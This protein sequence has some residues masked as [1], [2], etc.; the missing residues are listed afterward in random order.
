MSFISAP[1]DKCDTKTINVYFV[2]HGLSCANMEK[3]AGGIGSVLRLTQLDPALS[4]VGV[5]KS[6]EQGEIV[7]RELEKRGVVLDV[8]FTSVMLRA[9]E[10]AAFMFPSS[11]AIYPIPNVIEEGGSVANFAGSIKEQ[12]TYMRKNNPRLLARVNFGLARGTAGF[13]KRNASDYGAFRKHLAVNV[14]QIVGEQVWESRDVF[15]VVV[16]SHAHFIKNQAFQG[17]GVFDI[18]NNSMWKQTLVFCDLSF[19]ESHT[20]CA[21]RACNINK[22]SFLKAHE[23]P[24]K[25]W[26]EWDRRC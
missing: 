3:S 20:Y 13:L 10:T 16:V 18:L 9:I 4:S 1:A 5:G 22:G 17:S 15:N 8:I 21:N 24:R 26:K 11:L 19:K 6:V 7:A 23:F 12:E 14:N 25:D 2:T